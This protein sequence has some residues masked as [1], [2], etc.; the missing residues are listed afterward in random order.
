[1]VLTSWFGVTS[2]EWGWDLDFEL[3]I[4]ALWTWAVHIDS[5]CGASSGL[6][7]WRWLIGGDCYYWHWR[8]S[9]YLLYRLCAICQAAE[10]I[11]CICINCK[12]VCVRPLPLRPVG[13]S[14][15]CWFWPQ[16]GVA[17]SH[18]LADLERCWPEM[19]IPCSN[20]ELSLPHAHTSCS[21]FLWVALQRWGFG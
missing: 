7:H 13:P 14:N 20:G 17:A 6:W 19:T 21:Y 3:L 15:C 11:N 4:A 18:S 16:M 10:H 5:N 2:M 12:A 9:S 8:W 1:M